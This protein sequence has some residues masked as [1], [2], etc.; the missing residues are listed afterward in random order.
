[1]DAL[2]GKAPVAVEAEEWI[3]VLSAS[4]RESKLRPW[5]A[6]S[7]FMRA[8]ILLPPPREE[9][10]SD[11]RNAWDDAAPKSDARSAS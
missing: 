11:F 1:M 2:G 6:S 3:N 8:V 9:S 10:M 5:P 7:A 4:E